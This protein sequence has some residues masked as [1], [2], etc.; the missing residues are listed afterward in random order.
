MQ[1]LLI[2]IRKEYGDSQKRIAEILGISEEAYR[3][4]ER[5]DSQFK[6][7]EMFI[8]ADRYNLPIDEIFLPRKSTKSELNKI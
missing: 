7:D 5:G 6:M 1:G 3:N 4:K 2:G 8:I